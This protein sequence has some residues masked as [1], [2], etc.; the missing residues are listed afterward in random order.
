MTT[1]KAITPEQLLESLIANFNYVEAECQKKIK[2]YEAFGS[3]FFI[4]TCSQYDYPRYFVKYQNDGI[5]FFNSFSIS[6]TLT[7]A[8][9][10]MVRVGSETAESIT[11]C[12][13]Q[14]DNNGREVARNMTILTPD[15]YF[16][17]ELF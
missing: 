12:K 17:T 11:T 8:P 10:M 9:F 13:I 7:S 16:S 6:A 15:I 1:F 5:K 3:E 14:N 4:E 2:R